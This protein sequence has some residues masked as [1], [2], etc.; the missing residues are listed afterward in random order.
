ML[1][2]I[3]LATAVE[4]A[5]DGMMNDR[6]VV[7]LGA[8]LSM[9]PPSSL[10]GAWKLA[11]EAKAKYDMQHG[12]TRAPLSPDIEEQADFFFQRG[13]LSTVYLANLID[14]HVFAGIPNAGHSATADLLLC[15]AFRLGI[16]TNV[17]TL[18]ETA[19]HHLLGQVFVSID[20]HAAAAAPI[21]ASP[22]LKIH[23]CWTI[24]RPNTIWTQ[25]Q[26]A[27]EPVRSRIDHSAEWL[28]QQLLNRDLLIIGYSTDWTYLNSVLERALGAVNP[29]RILIVDPVA[30]ADYVAKAPFLSALGDACANGNY[31]LQASG[32]EFLDHLRAAYSRSFVRQALMHGV[33]L[34]Q[35]VYG[36]AP[37]GGL[38]EPPQITNQEFW[39]LR[40]DLLG[41]EPF[42][43]IVLS[44]PHAEPLVGLTVLQLRRL[45]GVADGSYW[46]LNGNRFRIVRAANEALHKVEARYARETAPAA[47]PDVVVAVGA[48]DLGLPANVAR[49]PTG[50][51][52]RGASSR[53]ITREAAQQEFFQ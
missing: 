6:Q 41:C 5:L 48:Q 33:V 28:A 22:L 46:M 31:H 12:A 23:G 10:P 11:E 8:G 3:D 17:D 4:Y 32:A 51:I 25:S 16:T 47:A 52:A 27:V 43:P 7:L 13:E 44:R 30:S 53:W 45:G 21:S 49:A 34:Y 29:A 50:T 37:T 20:G 26:I 1:Q 24:D 39:Q 35:E 36:A 15:G 38:L 40:R 9:A 42:K 19:G 18:I 14:N 2:N